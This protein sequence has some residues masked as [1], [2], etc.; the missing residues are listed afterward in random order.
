MQRAE[1]MHPWVLLEQN[2]VSPGHDRPLAL[3]R[4][5]LARK[6][7]QKRRLAGAVSPDQRQPVALADVKV[8]AAKQ[9]ALAL[10]EA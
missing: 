10:N 3:V 7:L 6:A 8:E 4:I 9:P 2:D 5:E 1:A